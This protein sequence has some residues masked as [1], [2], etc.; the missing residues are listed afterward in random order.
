MSRA[1]ASVDKTE[2]GDRKKLDRSSI[3]RASAQETFP[4]CRE[5]VHLSTKRLPETAKYLTDRPS[6]GRQPRKP[7]R[8]VES[9]C[10]CR[11]YGYRRPQRARQIV[12]LSGVSPGS[13]PGMSRA[14][15][16]VDKTIT[17]NRKIPDRSSICRASAQETFPEC[18]EIPQQSTKRLPETAKYLT[19]RP[20]VGR[21]P[22]KHSR[23]VERSRNCRQNG[24]RRP[25]K[26]RQIVH[27]SGVSPGNIA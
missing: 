26:A 2:T 18:R 10:I 20:S 24:Y 23:N 8:N 22:R 11:Q 3:C 7:F 4:E 16:S 1:G 12:H 5:L 14:S 17:E 9:W 15:A 13:I 25:Q 19:D 21:Q 6:V 27:L